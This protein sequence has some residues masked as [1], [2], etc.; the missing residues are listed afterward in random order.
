[1]R[2]VKKEAV[3]FYDSSH[4]ARSESMFTYRPVRVNLYPALA[5]ALLLKNKIQKLQVVL[6]EKMLTDAD[7]HFPTFSHSHFLIFAQ[8]KES[9]PPTKFE[10]WREGGWIGPPRI[11]KCQTLPEKVPADLKRGIIFIDVSKLTG[12]L[13]TGIGMNTKLG[14]KVN[15]LHHHIYMNLVYR[16]LQRHQLQQITFRRRS[17]QDKF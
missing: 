1:M 17:P 12:R 2:T 3:C 14:I 16:F 10:D 11:N 5:D 7:A 6:V 9:L 13:F 8:I 15:E 4:C